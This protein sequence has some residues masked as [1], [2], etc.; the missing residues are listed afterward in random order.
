MEMPPTRCSASSSLR[1]RESGSLL[2]N[3]DA[4]FFC[5]TVSYFRRVIERLL[6][7]SCIGDRRRPYGISTG[8][9][10]RTSQALRSAAAHQPVGRLLEDV[11]H[12]HTTGRNPMPAGIFSQPHR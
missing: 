6:A 1:L 3:V 7:V 5:D 9:L 2:I 12:R 11:F 4:N 8:K 10:N